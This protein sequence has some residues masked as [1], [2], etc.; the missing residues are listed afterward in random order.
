MPACELCHGFGAAVHPAWAAFYRQVELNAFS[1][2]AD[3]QAFWRAQGCPTDHAGHLILPPQE[4]AC[5]C[6]TADAG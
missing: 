4:T 1:C 2:Q 6:E 3:Y 5:G